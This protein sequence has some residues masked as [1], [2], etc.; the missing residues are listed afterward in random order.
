METERIN[1]CLLCIL[2][3][4]TILMAFFLIN[5]GYLVPPNSL[6]SK[7]QTRTNKNFKVVVFVV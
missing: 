7:N 4:D 6:S 3:G 5:L 2:H 1:V